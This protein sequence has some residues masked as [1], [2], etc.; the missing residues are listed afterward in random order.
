MSLSTKFKLL[1]EVARFLGGSPFAGFVG[2]KDFP[3]SGG[4][5]IPT[6]DPGSGEK[7]GDIHDMTAADVAKAVDVAN[8]AFPKWAALPQQERGAILLKLADAVEKHKAIIGQI[9]ALEAGKT[10]AR[11]LFLNFLACD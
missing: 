10:M 11:W 7:I 1:P 4:A 6:I 3:S 9:E 8:Q 2:G 5:L